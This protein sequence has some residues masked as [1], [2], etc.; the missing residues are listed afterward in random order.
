MAL[1][2]GSVLVSFALGKK[3]EKKVR[4]RR[5]EAPK[6]WIRWKT[7]GGTLG[8]VTYTEDMTLMGTAVSTN[9]LNAFHAV[10]A[11]DVTLQSAGNALKEGGPCERNKSAQRSTAGI[12]RERERHERMAHIRSRTGTAR[13]GTKKGQ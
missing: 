7:S 6:T 8:R 12:V 11:V 1:I 5:K 13:S 3:R 10:S 2:S 9:G 4:K